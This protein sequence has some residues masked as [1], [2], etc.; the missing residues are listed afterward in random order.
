MIVKKIL[1]AQAVSVLYF[2]CALFLRIGVVM[3]NNNED[4]G[5]VSK[6]R[7]LMK[8]CDDYIFPSFPKKDLALKIN[9]EKCLYNLHEECL[10]ARLN[11]GNIELNTL[12]K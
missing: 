6:I 1:K 11:T 3:N 2:A 8:Y 9:L 10:R 4:F 7:E 12:K 5:I